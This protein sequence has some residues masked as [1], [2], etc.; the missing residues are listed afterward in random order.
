[1]FKDN[2]C[3][4]FWMSVENFQLNQFDFCFPLRG[5]YDVFDGVTFIL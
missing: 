2:K 3:F 1:M 5:D 4:D